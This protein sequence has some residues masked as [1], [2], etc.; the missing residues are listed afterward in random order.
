MSDPTD[1]TA[2]PGPGGDVESRLRAHL[3]RRA[4]GARP[5]PDFDAVAQRAAAI[6]GRQRRALVAALVVALLLGPAAGFLAGRGA[7]GDGGGEVASGQGDGARAGDDPAGAEGDG[8]PEVALP[9]VATG[10]GYA[11]VSGNEMVGPVGP[12]G[13]GGFGGSTPPE[14]LALRTSAEGVAIRVYRYTYDDPEY[15]GVMEAP[16]W[17]PEWQPS[18]DCTPAGSVAVGLSTELAVGLA[19]HEL[20]PSVPGLSA[21]FGAFGIDEQDPH[22]WLVVQVPDGVASVRA[23]FGSGSVDEMAPVQGVA[24][25]VGGAV[26][27]GDDPWTPTGTLETFDAAGAPLQRLDL[28]PDVWQGLY[29]PYNDAG[30][31]ERCQPPPPPPPALPPA[32]EQPAD[33]NA[34]SAAVTVAIETVFDGS[35]TNDDRAPY[36]DDPTG[37]LP[38]ARAEAEAAFPDAV[39]SA[40]GIVHELVFTAPDTAVVRFEITTNMGNFAD[41]F[42]EVKLVDGTWKVTAGTICAQLSLAGVSCPGVEPF[43]Q[44]DPYA[45]YYDEEIA[46]GRGVSVESGVAEASPATTAPAG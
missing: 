16:P 20:W 35:L 10:R 23:T 6:G 45:P 31:Q 21:T 41:R 26:T 11:G 29:S 2:A 5:R 24:V 13:F 42:G 36:I 17:A 7:G 14:R 37:V 3:H 27:G 40:R 44:P 9:D 1:P 30:W 38:D 19:F 46:D 28:G 25:L 8:A 15:Y 18:G 4:Q 39:G 12:V 43:P 22:W 33:V 34:A 32:G